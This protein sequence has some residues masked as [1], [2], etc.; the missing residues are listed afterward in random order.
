MTDTGSF[1]F[2]STTHVTHEVVSKFLKTGISHFNSNQIY[3]N[4]KFERDST[5]ELCFK[6][7]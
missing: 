6:S 7:N 4:N 2:P 5:S 1:K 3:D